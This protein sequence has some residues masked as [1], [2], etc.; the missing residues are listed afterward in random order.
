MTCVACTIHSMSTV[1]IPSH[2]VPVAVCHTWCRLVGSSAGNQAVQFSRGGSSSPTP[3]LPCKLL[4]QPPPQPWE[5][6]SMGT[7]PSC[8]SCHHRLC[9]S[10]PSSVGTPVPCALA[11]CSGST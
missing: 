8:A 11:S 3:Q 1:G 4:H 7:L 9:T 6:G 10:S 5:V 2:H